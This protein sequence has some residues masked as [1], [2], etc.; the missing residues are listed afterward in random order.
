MA[1]DVFCNFGCRFVFQSALLVPLIA[2]E[3]ILF[4]GV[5]NHVAIVRFAGRNRSAATAL[6][7][8][9]S[10][11]VCRKESVSEGAEA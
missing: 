3:P 1:P 4:V 6:A 9:S 7:R 2:Y 10:L 11:V 8:N 5:R